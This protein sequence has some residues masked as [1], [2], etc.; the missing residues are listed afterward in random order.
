MSAQQSLAQWLHQMCKQIT[1]PIARLEPGEVDALVNDLCR[2]KHIFL[3]G[4]GREGLMM[5]ALTMRLYHLGLAAHFVG[6]VTTPAINGG[7]WLM[8]SAGPGQFATVGAL[9]AIA[10]AEN[11]NIAL[12]TGNPAASLRG[13]VSRCLV[14][15]ARTM[16]DAPD[17]EACL[18]LGSAYEGALFVFSEYLVSRMQMKLLISEEVMRNN[19]TNLE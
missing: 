5:R 9:T 18:P 11:A 16:H 13:N 15:A 1:E 14:L 12:I 19:H 7:D 17:A 3:Y 2:A 8:V 4:V 10:K 6:D